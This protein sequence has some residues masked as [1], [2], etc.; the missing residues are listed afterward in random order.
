MKARWIAAD[1]DTYEAL[2]QPG[3]IAI[4]AE[5]FH[6]NLM[7]NCP[8]CYDLHVVNIT[9]PDS[10]AHWDW[11]QA[12]LTLSPSVRVMCCAETCHW[13]LTHGEFIIHGDSTAKPIRRTE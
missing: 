6:Y 11:D 1:I 8:V 7:V 12:T 9:Q 13:N 2:T 3:D 10:R 5:N 4:G